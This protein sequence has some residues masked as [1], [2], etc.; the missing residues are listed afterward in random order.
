[1]RKKRGFRTT[2]YKFFESLYDEIH[3]RPPFEL[4]DLLADP[5][6][7]HNLADEQPELLA[8][9]RAKL[10]TFLDKRLGETG[11]PDPQSYQEITL[12]SV[13][14]VAIAVPKDQRL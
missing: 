7:Q 14:N 13:G 9:F 12:R 5:G 6:E 8:Q 2:R 3:H 10:H 4:Y 11:L 1:M